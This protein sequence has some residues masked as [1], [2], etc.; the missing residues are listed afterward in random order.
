VYAE[1]RRRT[2]EAAAA[3][4]A[5]IADAVY[6]AE[7]ERTDIAAAAGEAG[8]P[9]AGVW[10]EAPIAELFR[11]V[12]GRSGDASD[13]DAA[14]V[15]RQRGSRTGTID[16]ARIDAGGDPGTTV[17]GAWQALAAAL[18]DGLMHD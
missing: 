15:A 17:A 2:S 10:L 14:I 18:P 7:G 11:R 6:A 12:G 4:H 13:A 3:G 1:L 5:A 8:V 9:F 16:W